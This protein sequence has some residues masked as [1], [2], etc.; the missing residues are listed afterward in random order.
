MELL[1]HFEEDSKNFI[2]LSLKDK[3]WDEFVDKLPVP[4]KSCYIT[5]NELLQRI[6]TFSSTK[7]KEL[8]EIL[9]S[10]GNIQSGDFGEILSYFLFKEKYKKRNVDGPKKWRWK[11]DKNVAAP[12]TDVILFSIKKVGKPSKDDLLI[13]VESKMKATANSSYH[14]IK[15]AI[16]GAEKDSVSRIA[17]SLSW[18]RKKYKDESLKAGAPK[19]KLK[20]L[21]DSIER[22]I[23]SETVGEYSKQ[24]K[25]VAFVDKAFFDDEVKKV[26]T[27]P[28][29]SGASFEVIVISIK[30]LQKAYENVFT[31]IPKL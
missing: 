29:I 25:A 31:K 23:K 15:N 28:A 11:Q 3:E 14:P 5:E 16:E 1:K 21:V 10:L 17:N 7:E 30:D 27:V 22:F 6:E 13:S 20:E 26:V 8:S 9:P 4:Y 19:A 2:L 18:L 24:I 12:Y